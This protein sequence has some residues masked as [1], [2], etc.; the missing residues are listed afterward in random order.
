MKKLLVIA[1]SLILIIGLALTVFIKIYVTPE[2]VKELLIPLAEE[3]LNRKITIGEIDIGVLRGIGLK[4]FAIKESDQKSDFLVCEEFF[5]KFQIIPLLAK[6]VIIDEINIVSPS[7]RIERNT[8]GKYNFENIGRKEALEA[9]PE[10]KEMKGAGGLP[11]TLLVSK[12]LIKNASVSFTDLKRELPD[13]KSTTNVDIVMKS[14]GG[15]KIFSEGSIE[16]IID[17]LIVRKPEEKKIKGVSSKLD[18]ALH[19]D[20]ESNDIVIDRG[21]IAV[22][23]IAI[24]AKGAISKIR[25]SPEVDISLIISKVKATDILDLAGIVTDLKDITL[26]GAITG[27][28]KVKGMVKNPESLNAKGSITLD[29]LG[30]SYQEAIALIDG[31]MDVDNTKMNIDL[32]ASSGRNSARLTGSISSLFKNQNIHMNVY[33]K[34]LYLDELGLPVK[35]SESAPSE[36]T[37][38]SSGKPAPAGEAKP[39]KLNITAKG[40]VKI[41]SAVYKDMNMT[42]C[43]MTYEFINNRLDISK[44]SA[45][46]GKGQFDL[47]AVID[48]SKPGFIYSLTTKITSLHAEEIVNS[49]VPKAKDK[50]SGIITSNL[51]MSGK[52]TLPDAIK[53]NLI[54]DGDF[55]IRDGKISNAELVHELSLFVNVDELETIEFTKAEGTVRIRDGMAKLNSIFTSKDIA[56]DPNG[57]IGLDETLNLAFDLKLSPRLMDKAITSKIGKYMRDEEGWGTIPLLVSGTLSNPRYAPDI[58]KAGSAVIEKKAGKLLDKLFNKGGKEDQPQQPPP[59]QQ[60]ENKNQEQTPE[61]FFKDLFE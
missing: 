30:I 1:V 49:F 28:V 26:S 34:E 16:N 6:K 3:S 22:Q 27:D 43:Y 7:I 58:A 24:S 9:A 45:E 56:M 29:N 53:K 4:K 35:T 36:A 12:V 33:S 59:A 51:K 55:N 57:I 40:E 60:Q 46:A 19:V 38:A 2:K 42:G 11:I 18:Y 20:L 23:N 10:E 13:F 54:A 52:G 41:D 61:D 32:T 44:M 48:L 31:K 15:S 47:A 17:E 5:L 37:E 39:L 50:L 25:S 8:E 14:E 21:D